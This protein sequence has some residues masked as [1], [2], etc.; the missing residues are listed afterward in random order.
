MNEVRNGDFVVTKDDALRLSREWQDYTHKQGHRHSADNIENAIEELCFA[1][2][3][4]T[5][6]VR[7]TWATT[8]KHMACPGHDFTITS[9]A[10]NR[11][12]C[13]LC[14]FGR[15]LCNSTP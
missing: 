9:R 8:R 7:A 10:L 12:Y 15:D 6:E 5:E 1:L 14:G 4:T 11:E 3:A 13:R 2:G